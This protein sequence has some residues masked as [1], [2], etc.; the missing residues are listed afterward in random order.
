MMQPRYLQYDYQ[1][2][3][4]LVLRQGANWISPHLPDT[5]SAATE[6]DRGIE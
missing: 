1:K 3:R 6:E 5:Q 4:N 2:V